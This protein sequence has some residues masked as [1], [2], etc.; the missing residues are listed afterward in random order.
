MKRR[1]GL[2]GSSVDPQGEGLVDLL[3]DRLRF[4]AIVRSGALCRLAT[5]LP[6]TRNSSE[7]VSFMITSCWPAR[8]TCDDLHCWRHRR[9]AH[10][11]RAWPSAAKLG[12]PPV[13]ADSSVA[14]DDHRRVLVRQSPGSR[15]AHRREIVGISLA[16]VAWPIG[17]GLPPLPKSM[18]RD[19]HLTR[20]HPG[21]F[22]SRCGPIIAHRVSWCSPP[23]CVDR[24]RTASLT[25]GNTCGR[26]ALRPS[27]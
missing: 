27:A 15:L 12:K 2:K 24:P 21:S 18:A 1:T 26:H 23:E 16:L 25:R 5:S 4:R 3:R 7:L 6:A 14:Q 22:G 8:D 20:A 19:P 9:P 11:A 10:R 13:A 17:S